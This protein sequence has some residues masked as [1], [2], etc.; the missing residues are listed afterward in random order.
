MRFQKGRITIALR[1]LLRRLIAA[2]YYSRARGLLAFTFLMICSASVFYAFVEG[3][4]PLD[5]ICFSVITISTV[6]YDD[7]PPLGGP[8]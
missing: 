4:R 6:G 2:F 7:V 1:G 5:A 3:W 8:V